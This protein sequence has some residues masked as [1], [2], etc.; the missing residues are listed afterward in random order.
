MRE[1]GPCDVCCNIAAVPEISKPAHTPCKFMKQCKGGCCSIFGQ[2][3]RPK[4]CS[5]F[6][7]GWMRGAG[8]KDDRPDKNGVMFS[9][10]IMEN[11]QQLYV[12]IELKENAIKT[13]GRE[14]A[15]ETA[16]TADIPMIVVK[17]ESKPP[18]DSGDW[19]VV[20]DKLLPRCMRIVGESVERLSDDVGMYEL[21]KEKVS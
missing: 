13:T 2:P 1:C 19:V 4:V 11:G 18:T 15:I 7:C 9:R 21:V 20:S 8:S 12:A 6:L 3:E 17:Y 5:S 16:R 14:M 10:N